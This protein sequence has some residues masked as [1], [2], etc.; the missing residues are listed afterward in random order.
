M[1]PTPSS[2][3]RSTTLSL[4]FAIDPGTSGAIA[5]GLGDGKTFE[6]LGWQNFTTITDVRDFIIE[7]LDEHPTANP[8]VLLEHVHSSPGMGKK[9]AFTFGENF[10]EWKGLLCALRIPITLVK[11]QMW[12]R[13][14]GGLKGKEGNVRKNVLKAHA[15]RIY[16]NEKITL[17]NA[18]A[19]LLLDY[20]FKFEN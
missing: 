20:S 17:K 8:R 10:G 11:P 5:A 15:Q 2:P 19:L 9:S 6:L 3:D 13:S 4:G 16:P 1:S 14:I 7:K 12:Q 18:D